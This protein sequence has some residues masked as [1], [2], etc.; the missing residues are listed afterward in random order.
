LAFSESIQEPDFVLFFDCPLETMTERLLER[1]KT[2][3][4]DDDN[5]DTIRKRFDTFTSQS[6][7]VLEFY[8]AEG[9]AHVVSSVR[10]PADVYAE[11]MCIMDANQ[12]A[13]DVHAPPVQ[14][15]QVH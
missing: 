1:S 8:K 15:S 3:G 11:V 9:N 7:P 6:L 5:M 12:V 4:R 13:M 14:L 10:S 2:S